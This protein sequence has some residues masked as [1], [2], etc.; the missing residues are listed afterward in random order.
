M[1]AVSKDSLRNRATNPTKLP[2]RDC[3]EFDFQDLVTENLDKHVYTLAENAV[4]GKPT[5]G[6]LSRI[7]DITP[8]VIIGKDGFDISSKYTTALLL[9]T[10]NIDLTLANVGLVLAC[11]Q[12]HHHHYHH[13]II[14]NPRTRLTLQ[15]SCISAILLSRA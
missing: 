6:L 15:D 3:E 12:D 2:G 10:P 9:V 11:L 4:Q 8:Y 5:I 1:G 14:P 13:Q 7:L